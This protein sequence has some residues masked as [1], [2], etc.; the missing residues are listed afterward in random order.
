MLHW[1]NPGRGGQR[2]MEV[3]NH[4][5]RHHPQLLEFLF[6]QESPQLRKGA[7]WLMREAGAFCTGE[8]I[9][10]RIALNL[11]NGYGSVCLW[12]VIE[13]L[14]QQNY[15]QV[16][17][18]LRHLRRFDPDAPEMMFRQL[19]LDISDSSAN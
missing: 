17:R 4:I 10:I 18:G 8:K 12:D 14:D 6:D 3:M 2:M 13:K 9:L 16:I 5:F 15:Q 1:K 7:E 11:W 19:K